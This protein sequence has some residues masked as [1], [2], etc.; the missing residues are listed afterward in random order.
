MSNLHIREVDFYSDKLLAVQ[1]KDT[2]KIYVGVRWVCEGLRLSTGQIINQVRKIQSD[3]ILSNGYAK[4]HLP[5]NGGKQEVLTIEIDYLPLWL[6]KINANTIQDKATRE[7]LVEYQLRAK[8][9]LSDAFLSP[10]LV[11]QVNT[12]LPQLPQTYQEALRQL[13][14]QVEENEKLM[15]KA[16]KY[17]QFMSS[18][19]NQTIGQVAK[20]L[21]TGRTRLF[22][23]LKSKGILMSDNT[24]YQKYINLGYFDAREASSISKGFVFN[25]CQTLV[26]PK[27]IDMIYGLLWED[28]LNTIGDVK[29]FLEGKQAIH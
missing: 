14:D 16:Q 27:G 13:A 8:D 6:A 3:I 21:N 18:E 11:P 24:P 12:S 1:Q 20:V 7:K 29:A 25:H 9:V 2:G 23:L 22:K 15:P 17:D 28:K 5:T 10:Q 4:M 26:T 19:G